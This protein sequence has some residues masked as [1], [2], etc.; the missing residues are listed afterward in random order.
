MRAPPMVLHED[1]VIE[2]GGSISKR[3][4]PS[5]RAPGS[6]AGRT[7]ACSS[8]R[9]P[10]QPR[11]RPPLSPSTTPGPAAARLGR[12]GP[13]QPPVVPGQ[14]RPFLTRNPTHVTR[15]QMSALLAEG[16][17]IGPPLQRPCA[18]DSRSR[19]RWPPRA[20]RDDDR[21]RRSPRR[22]EDAPHG[23][24]DR[25][26]DLRRGAGRPNA[27]QIDGAHPSTMGAPPW[28]CMKML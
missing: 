23:M 18:R 12:G 9:L 21:G 5:T 1:V 16:G 26:E 14:P 11:V 3:G 10:E 17:H 13:T 15:S 2:A 20:N 7:R 8:P 27:M 28:F 19:T 22:H 6:T 25:A 4:C 24:A